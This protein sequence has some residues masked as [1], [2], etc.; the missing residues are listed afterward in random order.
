[1][2][3]RQFLSISLASSSAPL[4]FDTDVSNDKQDKDQ[5]FFLKSPER[6]MK[7]L[8]KL[9][10]QPYG[11]QALVLLHCW[12]FLDESGYLAKHHANIFLDTCWQPVL[13]PAFL[14]QSLDPWLDY[15]PMSKIMMGNDATSIEMAVGSSLVTKRVLAEALVNYEKRYQID[16]SRMLSVA[17]GFLHDNAWSL[18]IENSS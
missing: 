16:A 6:G 7:A 3:R 15:V 14:Q 18:Y 11:K 5:D 12:P 9:L 8:H 17:R 10:A 2:D 4:L 13:N 1:M